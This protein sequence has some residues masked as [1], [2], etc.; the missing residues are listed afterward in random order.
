MSLTNNSKAPGS[1]IIRMNIDD[2]GDFTTI[3]TGIRNQT[4]G[5]AI[6]YIHNTIC[7][8]TCERN[9]LVDIKL[10][11]YIDIL[12]HDESSVILFNAIKSVL[13]VIFS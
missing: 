13:N 1:I 11:C 3:V 2:N 12:R 9:L 5:L 10:F 4:Y 6:N 8:V 7:W